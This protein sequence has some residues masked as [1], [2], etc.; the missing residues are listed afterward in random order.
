MVSG[1][2]TAQVEHLARLARLDVSTAE[3]ERYR[4]QLD[5]ILEAVSRVSEVAAAD[6]SPMSHPQPLTNVWRADEVRP[7][8][9]RDEVLAA[10]PATEDDRFRVPRILDEV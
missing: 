5:H 9:D 7:G 3:V 6:V 1:L 2:T 4:G 10:A 8:V